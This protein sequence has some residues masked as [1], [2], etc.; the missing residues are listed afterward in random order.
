[1][2]RLALLHNGAAGSNPEEALLVLQEAQ[3]TWKDKKTAQT[4][5]AQVA[6]APQSP[7]WHVT[8]EPWWHDHN[9]L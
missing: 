2:V 9:T 5:A 8:Q 7:R 3:R 4:T 6:P 1:M